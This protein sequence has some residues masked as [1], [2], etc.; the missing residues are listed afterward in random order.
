VA[1][2]APR[3]GHR[4]LHCPICRLDLAAAGGA[5][6]CRNCHSFDLA[7]EGYVSLLSGRRRRPAQGGDRREQLKHRAAFLDAGHFDFITAAIWS[8]LQQ[9][10]ALSPDRPWRVLDSGCGTGHH[11]ARIAAELGPPVTGLGLDIAPAAARQAARRWPGLAFAVVDLWADWPVHDAAL[12]FVIS[13]FAP[14]NFAETA[15]VLELGGWLAVVYPGPNHLI[16]LNHPFDLMRQYEGKGRRY[17]DAARRY[18]GP[19]TISR[20]TRRTVLEGAG[21]RDAVLMGPNARRINPSTLDAATDPL[22]VTFD[23]FVL[24]ARKRGTAPGENRAHGR[25]GGP[26]LTTP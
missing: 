11:L 23:L 9:T 25:T 3:P 14:K 26:P 24:L 15:R 12:D 7:R 22:P 1:P 20:I 4:L 17:V 19:P 6:A 13:I 10:D 2:L 5:L 18:I 16:E 21:I 8:R